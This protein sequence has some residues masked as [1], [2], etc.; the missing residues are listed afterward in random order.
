MDNQQSKGIINNTIDNNNNTNKDNTL[1][2]RYTKPTTTQ[3]Q[4][5]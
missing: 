3:A 2:D 1:W 4:Q 5:A